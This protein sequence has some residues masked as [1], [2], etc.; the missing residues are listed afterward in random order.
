MDAVPARIITHAR[1]IFT[2]SLCRDQSKR[3]HLAAPP[4]LPTPPFLAFSA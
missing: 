2:L 3:R 4:C 1:E